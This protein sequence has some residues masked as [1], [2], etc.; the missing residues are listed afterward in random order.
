MMPPTDTLRD[1]PPGPKG[2]KE[3]QIKNAGNE[4]KG[5]LSSSEYI[6]T[7]TGFASWAPNVTF[8][9]TRGTIPPNYT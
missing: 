5:Q 8:T 4:L 3:H 6:Y 7:S 1:R 2:K 9:Q